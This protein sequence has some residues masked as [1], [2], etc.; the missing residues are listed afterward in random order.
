MTE[1][2][3]AK[4]LS[5]QDL[6][7]D[8]ARTA[9]D[10]M[11]SGDTEESRIEAFLLG[12]RAKGE[13]VDEI[14]GAVQSMRSNMLAIKAP[15]NAIDIVGTGGDGLN[16]PNISTAAAIVVSSCG[17]PVAKHGNRAASGK[18]GSSDVLAAL[19]VNLECQPAKLEKILSEIGI[20]FLFAPVHH[21]AMRHVAAVRRKLK[22]RTIF[23]LLGPLTNPARVKRHLIGAFAPEWL[24]PMAEALNLLGSET[25]WL[26]HGND[27]MDEMST[28][29]PTDVVELRRGQMRHFAVHPQDAGLPKAAL[30]D[31]QGG[32]A[33]RNAEMLR[34]LLDGQRGAYRDIVLLNSAAAL[35]V[36]EKANTLAKGV[37]AAAAAIDDGK[38][39]EKLAALVET[40]NQG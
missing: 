15:P 16:T 5:R 13:T 23:N 34:L 28:T 31:L 6:S 30:A 4:I 37:V 35:I 32:D 9:F 12:L 24:G 19:G 29:G 10:A 20:A 38:A 22:V 17:V 1:D 21:P 25:A 36:A 26:T 14:F 39:R 40:T 33:L 18:S 7:R 11:L 3:I 27:G 2:I 8:E